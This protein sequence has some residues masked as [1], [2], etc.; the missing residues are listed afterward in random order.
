VWIIYYYRPVSKVTGYGEDNRVLNLGRDTTMPRMTGVSFE[1]ALKSM[2]LTSHLHLGLKYLIW[3]LDGAW[4][5]DRVQWNPHFV[6][7][8]VVDLKT[9][10]RKNLNG[11]NLLL[12]LLAW[13]HWKWILNENSLNRETLNGDSTIPWKKLQP[14]TLQFFH[15]ILHH[16]SLILFNTK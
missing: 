13:N 11:G 1:V 4:K 16:H 12:R 15:F 7:L 6:S 9:K 14:L 3:I 8:E 2:K 5:P 10:L